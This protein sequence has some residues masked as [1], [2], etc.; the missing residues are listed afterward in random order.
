MPFGYHG[1]I[2]RVDLTRRSWSMDAPEESF[3]RLYGGGSAFG[4]YYLLKFTPPHCDPLGPENLLVL[5]LSVVTGAPISGLSRMTATAKSPLTGG[6]GDS[7]CGGSWPVQCRFAGLDAVVIQGVAPVPVYLW[8]RNG[9]VEIRDAGHLWGMKTGDVEELLKA[10]HGDDIE[11]LQ[12]GP[13][14]EKLVRYAAIINM[15]NRANG[16]TGMGAVMGSKK[17]K[18]VVVQ[19]SQKPEV[20]DRE[21]L[22]RLSRWGADKVREDGS[23]G[24]GALGTT[25]AVAGQQAMGGLPTRNWQ[26]GVF[27]GWESLQG[28]RMAETILVARDTCHGCVIRCKRV[29][30]K[31]DGPFVVERRYGGPEYETIA[32]FGSLCGISDLVAVAY[33]N[34]LCNQYGM[35]TIS[36]GAVVAWVMDCFEK[37]VLTEADTG[38][39]RLNFGNAEAMVRLVE[40]IGKREGIGDILAEGSARAARRFGRGADLVVAVKGQEMPAHMPQIKRSCALI[41][42]VNPFGADH[43]SHEHDPAYRAFPRKMASFGL[44]DPQPDASLNAEK[45]RF[46]L[47]MQYGYSIADTLNLCQFAWG[48]AWPLYD[49]DQMVEMVRAVT[50]WNVN[51]WELMKLGERRLNLLKAFNAREGIGAEADTLPLKMTKPLRGGPSDGVFIPPE[52]FERARKLYYAMAGWDVATGNPTSAKLEELG[53][54]WAANPSVP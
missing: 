7:Q 35:D 16:R 42:G 45:V 12:C 15:C 43:Q 23:Q 31:T 51:L 5:S 53:I 11:V 38:G 41:Y 47:Y 50:G 24:F 8:I 4:A 29:V 3:Y 39:L 26:S 19:G 13:A 40:M 21:T 18:A 1:K 2:L 6:I 32:T 54:G 49:F 46:A 52:E 9:T 37:G 27:E 20:A 28:Q 10:D 34:Q 14:G 48:P 25:G 33:A 36:C 44:I 22:K 30:E 17:L